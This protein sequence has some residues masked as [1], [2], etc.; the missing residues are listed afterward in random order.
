MQ[1]L[2]LALVVAFAAA[3]SASIAEADTPPGDR[4]EAD[5]A[6]D[7]FRQGRDLYKKNQIA[8][9]HAKFVAAFAVKKHWQIAL[10]LGATELLLERYREAAEHLS[11]A[12]RESAGAP[13]DNDI[14]W[15]RA[16][17]PEALGH[18]ATLKITVEPGCEL[19]LDDDASRITP[20]ADPIF[21]DAGHHELSVQAAG[22]KPT[23]ASIE[24]TA[25]E[26]REL[27]MTL[28]VQPAAAVDSAVGG[29]SS[30]GP[31]PAET[32]GMDARTVV[33]I[34]GGAL[35][36]VAVGIGLYFTATSDSSNSDAVRLRG[37]VG[38]QFGDPNAPG[39]ATGPG[40]TVPNNLCAQLSNAVYDRST[41][42]E[43]ARAA[44]I[45]AGVLGGA[46]LAAWFLWP[47]SGDSRSSSKT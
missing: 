18:V 41:A 38:Q 5:T 11:W 10:N 36:V 21:V 26:S 19:H 17:L 27:D 22:R 46:T 43:H 40:C 14:K 25:G 13:E 44:F 8:E 29:D 24:V 12:D 39:G 15:L 16:K 30:A 20:I 37:Q 9:A 28:P 33:A 1:R 45:T 7:L 4:I 6:R 23:Y 42:A 32:S 2:S 3:G 34:S 47:R 31:L 35:T